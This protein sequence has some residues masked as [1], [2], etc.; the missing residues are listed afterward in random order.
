VIISKD[1][2]EKTCRN[3][4]GIVCGIATEY[5]KERAQH[6]GHVRLH[7]MWY[8]FPCIRIPNDIMKEFAEWYLKYFKNNVV[9]KHIVRSGKHDDM[10]FRMFLESRYKEDELTIT[11]LRP[12]I[13]DHIDWLIGGSTINYHRDKPIRALYFEDEDL[14]DEL[15]E[16][17]RNG[18]RVL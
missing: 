14:V 3:D 18:K 10:V 9:Y 16:R 5:D 2:V 11:N 8:S 17:L 4:V 6:F 15:E 12:N 7:E 13:V 1:F